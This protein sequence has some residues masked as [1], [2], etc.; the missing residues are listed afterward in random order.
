MT[1]DAAERSYPLR[2]R[3]VLGLLV[4][5]VGCGIGLVLVAVNPEWSDGLSS[6]SRFLARAA[7]FLAV[8]AFAVAVGIAMPFIR[9]PLRVSSSEFV[10][11]WAW[12]AS[13]RT[14]AW[15]R[16]SSIQV[17]TPR[18]GGRQLVIRLTGGGVS[19]I[20]LGALRDGAAAEEDI[21]STWKATRGD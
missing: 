9:G 21:R 11:P 16:V 12:R 14:V 5:M 3:H 20:P 8:G 13:L 19:S 17:A 18:A 4:V 7:P 1:A 2:I 6:R 10:N 15:D